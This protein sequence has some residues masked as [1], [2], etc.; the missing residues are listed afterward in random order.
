MIIF[1]KEK[2]T[3]ICMCRDKLLCLILDILSNMA[4]LKIVGCWIKQSEEFGFVAE[5]GSVSEL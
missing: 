3:I 5:G 4:S 1:K 2:E